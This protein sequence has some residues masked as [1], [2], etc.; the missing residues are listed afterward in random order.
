MGLLGNVE[1]YPHGQ[2][3][4]LDGQ[5]YPTKDCLSKI[6]EKVRFSMDSRGVDL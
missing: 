6:I 4:L 2:E 3:Q 1:G 5:G